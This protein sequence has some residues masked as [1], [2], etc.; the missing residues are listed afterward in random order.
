[1]PKFIVDYTEERWFS[2]EIEADTE[3]EATEK[4][5]TGECD[6]ENA[7]E[8]G[9]EIQQDIRVIEKEGVSA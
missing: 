7:H 5:W 4:F 1:M 9:G 2:I 8:C 6:F 3:E